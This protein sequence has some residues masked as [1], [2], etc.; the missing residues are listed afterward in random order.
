MPSNICSGVSGKVWIPS[1]HC[2]STARFDGVGEVAPVEVGV[3]AGGEL[4]L[5]P[6]EG[7]RRPPRGFQWN[8]TSVGLAFGGDEP[9]GVDAEA[10]H[11]PVRAGM[12][13][14]DM[15]HIVWC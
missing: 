1:S 12:P 14:S 10:L 9:E 2:G 3:P 11:H 8:F 4:R 13:R 6:D 5:L 15:F 7:V